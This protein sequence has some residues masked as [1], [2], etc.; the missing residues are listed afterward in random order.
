MN[1]IKPNL[2]KMKQ[3]SVLFTAV[4]AFATIIANSDGQLLVPDVPL[5][6]TVDDPSNPV[7]LSDPTSCRYFYQCSDGVLYR[8]QC[9]DD[10]IWNQELK[11]I[12]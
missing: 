6:P 1:V 7:S 4:I 3:Y 10:L 2:N 9:P 12:A 11:V 8:N 5:C